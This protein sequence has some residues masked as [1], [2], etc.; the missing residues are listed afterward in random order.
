MKRVIKNIFPTEFYKNPAHFRALTLGTLYLGTLLAQ[1]FSYEKFSEVTASYGLPGGQVTA[2]VLAWAIPLL[3][4]MALPFLLSMR[5]N[6]KL[7]SVSCRAVVA[8][9]A[10]WLVVGVWLAVTAGTSVNSGLFG[11]T[12]PV[13]AGLWL[14]L[15]A[16]LWLWASMLVARE[17][18]AR[19]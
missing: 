6:T 12:I 19:K 17:L 13:P 2:V 16:V 3:T 5:T 10:L 1:L 8:T 4:V 9:P 11:A 15:L 14:I 18:P 7:W